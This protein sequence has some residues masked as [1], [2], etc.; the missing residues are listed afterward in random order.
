MTTGREHSNSLAE[1]A[2]PLRA[3]HE[4]SSLAL[5]RQLNP[6]R[7]DARFLQIVAGL[8]GKKSL[9][10]RHGGSWPAFRSSYPG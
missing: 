5:K 7:R 9:Q 2:A 3:E 8:K 4:A 1:P 6:Y 10:N